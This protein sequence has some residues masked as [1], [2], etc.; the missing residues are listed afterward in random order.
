MHHN[1]YLFIAIDVTYNLLKRS[2]LHP[3][4]SNPISVSVNTTY[5][6]ADQMTL[7]FK[8]FRF[9]RFSG[10][11][12]A[13]EGDGRTRTFG[14]RGGRRRQR[15]SR[16]R[17]RRNF[18]RRKEGRKEE[19][20]EEE[21]IFC[22]S[23]EEQSEKDNSGWGRR[24]DAEDVC[25]HGEAQGGLLHHP[26]PLGTVCREFVRHSRPRQ[27]DGLRHD[28]RERRVPDDGSR[29]A[30]RV[31]LVAT[32]EVLVDGIAVRASHTGPGQVRLHLQ[33][34]REERGDQVPLYRLRRFR[35]LRPL[36]QQ[37]WPS[38][39]YGETGIRSGRK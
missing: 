34:L 15:R 5:I 29:E 14:R 16:R 19:E 17:N 38:S 4:N 9:D 11:G 21:E 3:Q 24:P 12:G 35:P 28:G 30:S 26:A 36:L 37:R 13:Q 23:K 33:Q 8:C 10:R 6:S 1:Y 27:P 31:F 7:K 18:F 22:C 2:K 25:D 39:S 20:H 32:N